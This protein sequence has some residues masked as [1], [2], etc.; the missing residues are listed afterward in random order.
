MPLLSTLL[1]A[2]TAAS[3]D[4]T[5]HSDL[6]GDWDLETELG[7]IESEML[8]ME[9]WNGLLAGAPPTFDLNT[10]DVVTVATD[11]FSTNTANGGGGWSGA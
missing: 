11:N 2:D 6:G 7:L 4:A 1:G 9:G 10:A 5:G 8:S 3:I